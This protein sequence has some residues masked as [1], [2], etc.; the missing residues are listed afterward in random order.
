MPLMM[1]N[2]GQS[3]IIKDI[4]RGDKLKKKLYDM[5]LVEGTRISVVSGGNKGA[6]ILDVRGSR[7]VIDLALANHIIVEAA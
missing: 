5:G 4:R 1:L 2:Q 7:L 3:G 6:F